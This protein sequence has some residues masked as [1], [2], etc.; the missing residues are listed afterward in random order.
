MNTLDK[1]YV[2]LNKEEED[3]TLNW[4]QYLYFSKEEIKN[5]ELNILLIKSK[6]LKL[7]DKLDKLNSSK[8]KSNDEEDDIKKRINMLSMSKDCIKYY[9]KIEI[10]V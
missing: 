2:S 4:S 6:I 3:I 10:D 7:N 9:Y 5:A 1:E 8:S